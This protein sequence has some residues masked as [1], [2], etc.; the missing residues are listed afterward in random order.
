MK[1][2]CILSASLLAGMSS[3]EKGT[4]VTPP[5]CTAGPGGNLTMVVFPQHHGKAIVSKSSYPD[6]VYLKFGATEYPGNLSSFDK[7]YVGE[8][9]E[10]HVHISGLKCGQYYIYATGFDSTERVTGGI[11]YNTAQ[12]TGEVNVIVPVTE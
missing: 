11:P 8:A 1:Y 2:F 3:C 9:G 4:P 12:S 6:T 10:D 5:A 7:F